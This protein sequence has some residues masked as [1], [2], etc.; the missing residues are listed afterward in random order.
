MDIVEARPPGYL[1]FE[2][3]RWLILA[4]LLLP[5]VGVGDSADFVLLEWRLLRREGNRSP[6]EVFVTCGQANVQTLTV[7]IESG[8]GQ[9]RVVPVICPRLDS[10]GS[11]R[12]P[13]PAGH[14]PFT[15]RATT[16]GIPTL[17]AQIAR[18]GKPGDTVL[19]RVILP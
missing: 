6:H 13:L 4:V 3:A 1:S 2:M 12:I 15:L 5:G 10:R 11:A 9:T 16:P 8:S 14:A 17:H 18:A 7:T 19:L